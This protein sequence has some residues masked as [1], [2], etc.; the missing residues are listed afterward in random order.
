MT[1]Q[2][3]VLL[4]NGTSHEGIECG[5]ALADSGYIPIVVD[6]NLEAGYKLV[7]AEPRIRFQHAGLHSPHAYSDLLNILPSYL[8]PFDHVV[9][10]C[11][12]QS[13]QGSQV[14]MFESENWDSLSKALLISPL[15]FINSVN[16]NKEVKSLILVADTIS[17]DFSLSH[18]L[19]NSLCSFVS[20]Q[21]LQNSYSFRINSVEYHSGN[22]APIDI[23]NMCLS[24]INGAASFNGKRVQI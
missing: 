14:S 3:K 2:K 18:P 22:T 4:I 5:K 24:I 11:S 23:A 17:S 1:K 21:A 16:L 10:F 12:T 7:E 15:S 19:L 9:F 20:T 6:S 8:S 13:G